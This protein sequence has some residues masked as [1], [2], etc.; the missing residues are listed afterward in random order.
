MC[1]KKYIA[2]LV[3]TFNNTSKIQQYYKNIIN[4]PRMHLTKNK[5]LATY[6]CNVDIIR[7]II[8]YH[9]STYFK[10]FLFE[11]NYFQFLY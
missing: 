3:K 7:L 4:F 5:I 8:C 10:K 9:V 11:D 2:C 1:S 6:N